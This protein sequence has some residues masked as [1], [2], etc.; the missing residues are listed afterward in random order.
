MTQAKLG[1]HVDRTLHG[2]GSYLNSQVE[3]PVL[4]LM[5]TY[6]PS[7]MCMTSYHLIL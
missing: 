4:S 6:H 5:L 2:S 3:P 1:L 7:C